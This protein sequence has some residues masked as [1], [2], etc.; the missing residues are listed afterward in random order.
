MDTP[1]YVSTTLNIRHFDKLLPVPMDDIIWYGEI[2][3]KLTPE[4]L[5]WLHRQYVRAH[6]KY[7]GR[8]TP[9]P[10]FKLLRARFWYLFL[11]VLHHWKWGNREYQ[12]NLAYQPPRIAG[13][14]LP[15]S[16]NRKGLKYYE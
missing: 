12:V 1:I 2:Y 9:D 14:G 11:W 16:L 5:V 8:I 13:D 6:Q 10:D 3:R 7:S 15:E 4:Y